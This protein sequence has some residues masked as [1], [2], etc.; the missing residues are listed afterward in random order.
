MAPFVAL[1]T[2]TV[3]VLDLV[4]LRYS[5]AGGNSSLLKTND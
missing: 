4:G 3:F 5:K 1:H 2:V